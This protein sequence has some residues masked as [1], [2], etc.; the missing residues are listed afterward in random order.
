MDPVRNP[1]AP[2]TVREALAVLK[3][4]REPDYAADFSF[5]DL[6]GWLIRRPVAEMCR[7]V[8]ALIE[9]P[10]GDRVNNTGWGGYCGDICGVHKKECPAGHNA[11]AR[12]RASIIEECAKVAEAQKKDFLSPEYASNQPFGSICERFACD[13]VAKA[14]RALIEQPAESKS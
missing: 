3:W 14:I 12:E 10:A 11:T 5:E 7:V 9:Q 6:S 1:Y 8:D 13:E 4:L 2:G